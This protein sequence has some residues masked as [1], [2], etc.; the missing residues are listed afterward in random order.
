MGG[1]GTQIFCWVIYCF[2]SY[3]AFI[4]DLFLRPASTCKG[5]T[6]DMFYSMYF[7]LSFFSDILFLSRFLQLVYWIHMIHVITQQELLVYTT[8]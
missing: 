3:F 4:N 6:V 7:P 5:I 2:K 8:T 1:L